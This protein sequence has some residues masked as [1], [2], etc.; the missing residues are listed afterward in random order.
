MNIS[1]ERVDADHKDLSSKWDSTTLRAGEVEDDSASNKIS[2]SFKGP[3]F[4]MV[5]DLDGESSEGAV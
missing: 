2:I 4:D 1:N 3:D 5:G